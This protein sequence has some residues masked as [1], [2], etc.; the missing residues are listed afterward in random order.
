MTPADVIAVEAAGPRHETRKPVKTVVGVVTRHATRKTLVV[1]TVRVV[2][3]PRY[4]KYI[5][6]T[7]TFKAHDEKDEARVGARVRIASSRPLSKTKHWR[8]VE[9]L[10]QG[11]EE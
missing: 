2:E 9:I 7:Q 10:E 11:P 4:H 8:L 1:Q 3:H 6:Q 5:R